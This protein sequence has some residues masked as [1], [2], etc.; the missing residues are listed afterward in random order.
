[1]ITGI[2]ADL[3]FT[4]YGPGM[5]TNGEMRYWGNGDKAL[6]PWSTQ[7]DA[8]EYTIDV[9][10]YGKGVREGEGG[11]FRVRSGVTSVREMAAVYEMVY[12][13][14]VVV[15][16]VGRREDLERELEGQRRVK[17]AKGADEYMGLAAA[18]VASKGLWE[19][20]EMTRLEEMREPMGMEAWLTGEKSRP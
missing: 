15:E 13:E 1:M 20:G 3:L 17:G 2:F 18:V 12:G 11:F 6:Y 16:R 9:L 4:A 8:A 19:K 5:F 10:L 7:D 14:K